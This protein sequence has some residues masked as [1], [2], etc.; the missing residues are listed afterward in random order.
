MAGNFPSVSLSF[1][2]INILSYKNV[3][4]LYSQGGIEVIN[5]FVTPAIYCQIAQDKK[6]YITIIL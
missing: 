4:H 2:F 3:T 6:L 1:Y 5:N